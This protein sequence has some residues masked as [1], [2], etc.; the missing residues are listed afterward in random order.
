MLG[1]L[2]RIGLL[3]WLASAVYKNNVK[4]A[5][6]GVSPLKIAKHM[7]VVGSDGVHVGTVDHLAIQLTKSDPTAGGR[8]HVIPMESVATLLDGKVT[9]NMKAA[10]AI[11]RQRGVADAVAGPVDGKLAAEPV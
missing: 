11:Q 9:L 5:A 10:A 3:G 4:P 2:I 6:G 8:H 7:E 1:N